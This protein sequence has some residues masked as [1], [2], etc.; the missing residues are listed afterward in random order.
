MSERLYREAVELYDIAFSWDVSDEVAWLLDLIGTATGPVLEPGCGTGRMLE[1]LARRGVSATGVD[2]SE[3]M[4]AFARQRLARWSDLVT[5]V[6]AD[7]VEFELERRFA[8]AI[9]PVNTLGYLGPDQMLPHLA[10]VADHLEAGARYLVQLDLRSAESDPRGSAT[11]VQ[12]RQGTTVA[13]TWSVE[14]WDQ[15]RRIE[16]HRSKLVVSDGPRRGEIVD[17]VH[18]I[19]SWT[20]EQWAETLAASPFDYATVYDG[21]TAGRPE[22]P[23]GTVGELLWHELVRN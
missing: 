2:R 8:G 14:A 4:V 13:T 6:R 9:C 19:T 22:V 23:R 15:P 5:I 11:W 1:E 10:S 7:M 16:R 20:G 18:E 12:S 21:N 17:E 3:E